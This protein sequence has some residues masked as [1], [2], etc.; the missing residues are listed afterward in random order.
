MFL[1]PKDL[2]ALQ[3]W[4]LQNS[5]GNPSAAAVPKYVS[6]IKA[7]LFIAHIAFVLL[8]GCYYHRLTNIIIAHHIAP[9]G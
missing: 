3:Y 1:P 4:Q 6:F 2:A 7:S 5:A 9:D 8:M